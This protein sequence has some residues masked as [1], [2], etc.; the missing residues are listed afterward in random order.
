MGTAIA[1]AAPFPQMRTGTKKIALTTT[2][3]KAKEAISNDLNKRYLHL[4]FGSSL[5]LRRIREG[6]SACH[7]TKLD[8]A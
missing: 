3:D 8:G 7:K 6:Q 5:I 2:N 4:F 1:G